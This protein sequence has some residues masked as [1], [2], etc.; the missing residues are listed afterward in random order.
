MA[1][2]FASLIIIREKLETIDHV[3]LLRFL[4]FL[5]EDNHK[6]I[7]ISGIFRQLYHESA[8]DELVSTISTK[9]DQL[10]NINMTRNAYGTEITHT[11]QRDALTYIGSYLST[12]DLD[13]D[14]FTNYD[15]FGYSKYDH[16]DQDSN[17]TIKIA[18][19]L[20]A[21]T[22]FSWMDLP[23]SVMCQIGSYLP[24]ADIFTSWNHINRRCLV[25][26]MKPETLTSWNFGDCTSE[27]IAQN[28]PKYKID[29]ILSNIKLM[30]YNCDFS[31]IMDLSKLSLKKLKKV[32][33]HPGTYE[34]AYIYR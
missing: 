4:K 6:S 13:L 22:G 2:P 32:K 12:K 15:Q 23:D 18:G 29:T 10:C 19:D 20:I 31:E 3:T 26:G 11:T 27:N 14:L 33:L 24:T 9:L 1:H 21:A 34:Y 16:H 8:S 7:I 28:K 17:H 30:D 5:I 25:T